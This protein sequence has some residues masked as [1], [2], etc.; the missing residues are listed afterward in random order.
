[1]L[2]LDKPAKTVAIKIYITGYL[3]PALIVA[4]AYG[5]LKSGAIYD[6]IRVNAPSNAAVEI[7]PG[8]R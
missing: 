8:L 6:A 4:P 7:G 5:Y 1:M 2:A 3:R